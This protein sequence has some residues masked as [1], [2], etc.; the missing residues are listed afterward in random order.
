MKVYEYMSIY[1]GSIVLIT[2]AVVM[3][4]FLAWQ[5]RRRSNENSMRPR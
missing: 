5:F 1:N 4:V 3:L 2:I